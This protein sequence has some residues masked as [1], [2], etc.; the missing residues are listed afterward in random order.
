MTFME[1]HGNLQGNFSLD[2]FRVFSLGW[3]HDRWTFN[4][5]C[6]HLSGRASVMSLGL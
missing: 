5:H 6:G 4:G 2:L 1:F 3:T